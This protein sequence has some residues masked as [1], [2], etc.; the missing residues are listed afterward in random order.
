MF[1]ISFSKD[2]CHI[3]V[4]YISCERTNVRYNFSLTDEFKDEINHCCM[5]P[6]RFY[7]HK[8]L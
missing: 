4:Q 5:S 6:I 7:K 3:G 8:I 1:C 2:G